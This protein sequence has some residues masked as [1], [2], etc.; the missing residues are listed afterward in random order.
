MTALRK[1]QFTASA[2]RVKLP[3]SWLQQAL[4]SPDGVYA[5]PLS[6]ERSHRNVSVAFSSC[7]G[8][9]S[10]SSSSVHL[11]GVP[12]IKLHQRDPVRLP[13]LFS[14]FHNSFLPRKP[15]PNHFI[16]QSKRFGNL[17]VGV[18]S[19]A[20]RRSGSRYIG[21]ICAIN[22]VRCWMLS[23]LTTGHR[24]APGRYLRPG[25]LPAVLLA[26]L[27]SISY[28]R[29]LTTLTRYSEFV[30]VFSMNF[31]K[32]LATYKTP[33]AAHLLPDMNRP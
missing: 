12:L 4:V 15:H 13:R 16:C 8:V 33:L 29:L 9:G 27:R 25:L 24:P 28:A 1:F 6:G 30:T 23:V 3:A 18:A 21:F 5:M 11:H 10:S 7:A 17:P 26:V 14:S 32:F 20:K 22:S 19:I 2:P 31:R